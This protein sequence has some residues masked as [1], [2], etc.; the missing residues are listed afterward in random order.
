VKPKWGKKEK[1]KKY[2]STLLSP[3]FLPFLL[4]PPGLAPPVTDAEPHVPGRRSRHVVH[5]IT[6]EE[7]FE[8][9]FER[10]KGD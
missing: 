9:Q 8:C 10:I 6:D 7:E 5:P 3:P 2:S 4:A 1:K